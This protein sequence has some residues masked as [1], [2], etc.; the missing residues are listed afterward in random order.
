MTF[1]KAKLGSESEH[2]L[3]IA[4][5][6]FDRELELAVIDYDGVHAL[7]FPCRRVLGGWIK[8]ET[9]KRLDVHPNHWREWKRP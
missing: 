5:A 8:S 9:K 6:P 7:A 3:P 1:P 4:S 2:W